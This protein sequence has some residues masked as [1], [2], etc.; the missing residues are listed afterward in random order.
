M[1]FLPYPRS[2]TTIILLLQ[3]F[4]DHLSSRE[5]LALSYE[6]FNSFVNLAKLSGEI[7]CK[8]TTN[9]LISQIF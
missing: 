4:K 3:T 6:L 8:I 7:G 2:C 1:T 9:F 5:P